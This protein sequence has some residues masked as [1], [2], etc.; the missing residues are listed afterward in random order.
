MTRDDWVTVD[1]AAE[2]VGRSRSTVYRWIGEGTVRTM[3]PMRTLWGN[4]PDL[5]VAERDATSRIGRP[6]NVPRL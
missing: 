5:L 2:R 6:R 1:Q 4:V 3:C